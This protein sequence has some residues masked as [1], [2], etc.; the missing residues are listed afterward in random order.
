MGYLSNT[1]KSKKIVTI[2][3]SDSVQNAV[4]TMSSHHVGSVLVM[5][6]DKIVGI[7]TER[8]LLNKVACNACDMSQQ[9]VSEVMSSPVICAQSEQ[10]VSQCFEQMEETKCRH[11]PIVDPS[12]KPVAMVTMRDLL[13]WVIDEIKTENG[14]LLRYI[15]S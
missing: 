5:D 13:E 8:D 4:E 1:I 14:E 10:T 12:G 15:Q 9:K 3:P 2:A 7:F 6:Q 11:I